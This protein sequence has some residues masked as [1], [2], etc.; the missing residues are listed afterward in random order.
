V[1]PDN[2]ILNKG[3]LDSRQRRDGNEYR[4]EEDGEETKN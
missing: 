3:N 4:S 1:I 2:R